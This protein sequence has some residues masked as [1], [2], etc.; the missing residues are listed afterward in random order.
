VQNEVE[1]TANATGATFQ[2]IDCG[3][4]NSLIDGETQQNFIAGKDGNYAV[5]V[6]QSGCSDTSACIAVNVTGLTAN[7][8]KHNIIIYPNPND[9]TFFIDL[10]KFYS[11]VV[12]AISELDSRIIQMG[13]I[14]YGKTIH[15]N[16]DASPGMYMVT[17][18]SENERAIFKIVKN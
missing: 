16:L 13:K 10:G 11:N 7:T 2:W 4:G 5:I 6:T 3:Y 8:F 17:I 12:V 1:L 9:G 14:N 15:M 18:I